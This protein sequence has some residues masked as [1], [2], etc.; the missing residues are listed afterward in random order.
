MVRAAFLAVIMLSGRACVAQELTPDL[1]AN[2]P[3]ALAEEQFSQG[4]YALSAQSA[5]Q[6]LAQGTGNAS[7]R[8]KADYYLVVSSIK[9]D[10]PGCKAAALEMLA[11]PGHPAYQQRVGFVLAEYYFHHNEYTKAIPLF[12]KLS[13]S[14]LDNGEIADEKFELAY[15]YFNSREFSKAKPLLLA[16]KEIEDGRY[17]KAANYYFGLI[18]YNENNYR[19]ALKSFDRIK[20]EKE[21]HNVVPYYLT[22]IYYFMGERERALTQAETLLKSNEKSFYDNELHLLAAQCLF[23][24]QKFDS[25]LPYFEFY[26]DHSTRIR[27]QDLYEMA[28]CYYQA[29]AWG[30]AEEKFKLLSDAKDSLGQTSMYLLGDC[31]LKTGDKNSAR[32][33]FGICSDMAFNES[34]QEASL[35][36]YGKISYE[37]G[38]DDQALS[39]FQRLLALFPHTHYKDETNTFISDLL[40]KTNN[41]SEALAHLEQVWHKDNHFKAVYQKAN[42][43]CAVQAFRDGKLDSANIYFDRS[44]EY[45]VNPTFEDAAL[46]WKGELAYESR[47]FTEA[48]DYSKEFIAKNSGTKAV[49]YISPLATRQHAYLNIGYAEM[50]LQDFEAAQDYFSK[51]QGTDDKDQFSGAVAAVKLADA[52]FMQKNYPRALTLY[53]KIIATDS[54]DADYARYQKSILLGLQGK[55]QEKIAVL[56]SILAQYPPS[57]YANHARYEIALTDIEAGKYQAAL[58]YLS[59]LT[60]SG[61]DKSFAPRAWMKTGFVYQQ[62]GDYNRAIAAYKEVV[63]DYPSSDDRSAALDALKNLYIQSNQPSAYSQMLRDNNLP[64]ADSGAVDSTYYAAAESQF[65]SGNWEDARKAFSNYLQQYP[66][67][68]FATNAHYYRAESNYQ[69]KNYKDAKL[70][71]AITLSGPWNDFVE[72][73]ALHAANIAYSEKDYKD[74]YNYFTKLRANSSSNQLREQALVGL[75]KSGFN[76]AMYLE[77]GQYA[78]SLL[79]FQ[80]ASA[81]TINSALYYKAKTLQNFDSGDA[82]MKIY[83]QLGNNQNGEVAAESRYQIAGILFTEGKLKEAEVA[84]NEAIHLSAGYDYWIVKSYILLADILTKE[85]DLFNAKATL[86]SIV[87]HTGIEELKKQAADKLDELKKSEKHHSKLSEE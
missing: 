10:L 38:F 15:C 35:I 34:Q 9:S 73:S 78:D 70:D 19:E 84:A 39:A 2:R 6:Y 56:Q 47:H 80:G 45:T 66:N 52:V 75:M 17:F 40:L 81:E 43:D 67:G 83:K 28:Y 57:T 44:L 71:Y 76:S 16:I 49:A 41:Y 59:A 68:I 13:V 48:V 42:F 69:L 86:E 18:A 63:I 58:P 60:D 7:E 27:K 24:D 37:T 25:A 1:P 26:Y 79:A 50:E 32:N 8:E 74:A 14:N 3:L 36:L 65:A 5:S 46:F 33:A 62:L 22:E 85:G 12:E 64:S 77:T 87:Q 55:N 54:T 53:E 72:N 29:N 51:A 4:H 82:A 23:E 20:D 31:Y 30:K 61:S 11:Q 21:Y